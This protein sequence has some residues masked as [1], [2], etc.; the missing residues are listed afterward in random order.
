MVQ[1]K[2]VFPGAA[3]KHEIAIRYSV[4]LGSVLYFIVF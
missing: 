2:R 3:N 4:N 1:V